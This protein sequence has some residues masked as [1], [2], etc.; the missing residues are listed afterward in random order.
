M[1]EQNDMG[2]PLLQSEHMKTPV[3]NTSLKWSE[4][5][6]GWLHKQQQPYLGNEQWCRCKERHHCVR[7]LWKPP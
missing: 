6:K 1:N 3:S 7:S 2:R 5:R 4:Q